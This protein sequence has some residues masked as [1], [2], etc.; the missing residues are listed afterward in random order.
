MLIYFGADHGGFRLKEVLKD[1]IRGQ[2]YEIAD[3][4]NTTYDKNDD[5]PDF[6]ALVAKQISGDPERNRGILICRSGVGVD[7]VAN[8]FKG[9]RSV[10]GF[11][12]DH[13]YAARRDDDVNI[14]SLAA[15]FVTDE[16]A[17]KMVE[18]FLATKAGVDERYRLRL[19]KIA[20]L[21]NA[22]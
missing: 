16:D 2:G 4:G 6:A 13:V 12:P 7:I 21:E 22:G 10:L 19:K 20:E 5:Y 17:K 18:V 8:K 3:L 9:V 15:E 1:L 14:L 11:S